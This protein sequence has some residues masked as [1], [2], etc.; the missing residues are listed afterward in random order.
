[1][2]IDEIQNFEGGKIKVHKIQP[3]NFKIDKARTFETVKFKI[4]KFRT[5]ETVKFKIDKI[6][7]F[8]G[9]KNSN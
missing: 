2:E 4:D 6:Q 8:E 9:G 3:G 1:M 7:T 5:F